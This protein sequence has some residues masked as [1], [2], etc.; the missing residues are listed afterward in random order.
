MI[1]IVKIALERIQTIINNL[2]EEK[3]KIDVEK[4]NTM[5]KYQELENRKA[6]LMQQRQQNK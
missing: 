5:K 6:Q 4:I 1:L 3:R 2:N